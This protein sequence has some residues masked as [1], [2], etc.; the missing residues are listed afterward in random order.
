[1]RDGTNQREVFGADYLGRHE[2]GIS[3]SAQ[4]E[5]LVGL[6]SK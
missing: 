1:M 2:G 4:F 5:V 3:E 6:Q